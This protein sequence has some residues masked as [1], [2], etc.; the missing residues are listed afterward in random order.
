MGGEVST[1][2]LLLAAAVIGVAVVAAV[3]LTR[4]PAGGGKMEAQI[5]NLA[6]TLVPT[7]GSTLNSAVADLV[8]LRQ[9]FGFLNQAQENLQRQIQ[10]IRQ[11][12][13]L[14]TAGLAEKAS[15]TQLTLQQEIATAQGLVREVRT[16]L[17]ERKKQDDEVQRAVR[18]LE[19]V[20]AGAPTKGAAGENILDE[21]FASFPPEMVERNFAVR[22]KV[23]EYALVLAGTDKRM[24]IDSKWPATA[25]VERLASE[26]DP[27][28]RQKAVTEVRAAIRR[29]VREVAQYIDPLATTDRAIAAV[30]DAVYPYCG[31]LTYEAYRQGVIVMPYSMIVPYVLNL[32]NLHL[33]YSR[34]VDLD[35]LDNALS[36]IERNVDSLDKIL[37]NSVQR[38]AT[39][40]SNAFGEAKG[41]AA[42]IKGTLVSI[43]ALPAVAERQ[44]LAEGD[45]VAGE[46]E[47]A[48][49]RDVSLFD[50]GDRREKSR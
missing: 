16:E 17:A 47:A 31:E 37:E 1:V 34:T 49:G 11:R 22:G 14:T 4:R 46:E 44:A 35:S 10:E 43:R 18:H 50:G 26:T 20:L 9:G 48:P 15:Q 7:I 27:A 36:D 23:V 40:I 13:E 29:K 8:Q 25:E 3:L 30:P 24:P 12:V 6:G 28:A 41:I 19:A 38:G 33:K 45:I 5:D 21:A 2:A 39:M 42:R 32:Y